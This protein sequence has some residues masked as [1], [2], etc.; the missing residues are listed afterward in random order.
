MKVLVIMI[1]WFT[2][3]SDGYATSVSVEFE[4]MAA[5][6]SAGLVLQEEGAKGKGTNV[7][8]RFVCVPKAVE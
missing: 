3:G 4:S 8:W 5:C 2:D 6:Q 1:A 7:T